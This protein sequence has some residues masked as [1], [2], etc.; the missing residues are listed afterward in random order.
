MRNAMSVTVRWMSALLL[1]VAAVIFVSVRFAGDVHGAVQSIGQTTVADG[2]II[3]V[4]VH[5]ARDCKYCARWKG[6]VAGE[7]R[8][9]AWASTHP[10]AQLHIVERASIK[11]EETADD[12]PRELQWLAQD[13]QKAQRMRPGTPMFEVFVAH[14]LVLRKYGLDSWDDEVFPAVK[15]LD[16]RRLHGAAPQ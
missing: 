10:G 16:A 9:N 13:N 5:S 12:Y 15:E 6:P 2:Q 4:V 3:E 1:S 11:S 14:N 7:A 8:F